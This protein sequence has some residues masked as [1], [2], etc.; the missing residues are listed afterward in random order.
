MK[1]HVL[2]HTGERPFKC[3]ICS[4]SFNRAATLKLHKSTVHTDVR[5]EICQICGA[6]FKVKKNLQRHIDRHLGKKMYTCSICGKQMFHKTALDEHINTHTR[7]KKYMCGECDKF[8]SSYSALKRHMLLH[9]GGK[10]QCQLC[11]K[12][13]IRKEVWRKHMISQ[14]GYTGN[15]DGLEKRDNQ[16]KVLGN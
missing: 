4:S 5:K 10:I 3:D 14:H 12:T 8:V 11:S 1:L 2:I 9:T 7:E 13:F 15:E 6:G 16:V